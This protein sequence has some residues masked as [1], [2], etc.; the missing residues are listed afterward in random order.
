MGWLALAVTAAA[1]GASNTASST[2]PMRVGIIWT[3]LTRGVNLLCGAGTLRARIEGVK[4]RQRLF[5]ALHA[6]QI[7][8]FARLRK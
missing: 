6:S 4:V 7:L 5:A 2:A 1:T 8:R 3:L